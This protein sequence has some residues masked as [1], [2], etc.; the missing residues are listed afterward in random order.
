MRIAARFGHHLLLGGRVASSGRRC[1]A[2]R[3]FPG[4]CGSR[5]SPPTLFGSRAVAGIACASSFVVCRVR[6]ELR[7]GSVGLCHPAIARSGCFRHLLRARLANEVPG[8]GVRR[9]VPA[10]RLDPTAARPYASR[11]PIERLQSPT[12]VAASRAAGSPPAARTGCRRV[13]GS[14]SAPQMARVIAVFALGRPRFCARLGD[15]ARE[16]EARGLREV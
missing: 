10:S 8:R 1:P 2:G 12:T 11:S 6:N 15:I 3:R 14:P 16:V 7:L 13:G 5:R 4:G 9:F